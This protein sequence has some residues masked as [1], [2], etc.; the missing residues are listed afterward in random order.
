MDEQKTFVGYIKK[1]FKII[2]WIIGIVVILAI[3]GVSSTLVYKYITET[4]PSEKVEITIKYNKKVCTDKKFPLYIQIR[5]NSNK[6]IVKTYFD[7]GIKLKGRSSDLKE[8]SY[9]DYSDDKIIKPN[10]TYKN[11]WRMPKFKTKYEEYETEKMLPKLNYSI[12][13][14]RINFE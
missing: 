1:I 2:V 9:Q 10:N 6:T 4:I 7:V 5:N 14:K 12:E 11:C 8:Y 13:N 3:V